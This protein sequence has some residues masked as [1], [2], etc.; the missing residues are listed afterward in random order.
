MEEEYLLVDL[1]NGHVIAR[2]KPTVMQRCREVIGPTLHEELLR[3]QI[4]VSSPVFAEL[5]AASEFFQTIRQC[6]IKVL[7][8][9]GIGLY[10]AGSHPTARWSNQQINEGSHY[11]RLAFH[12]QYVAQRSLMV[13]L[14]I[15]VGTHDIDR[16]Q[17]INALQPWLP[18]FV[19]L[20]TSSPFWCGKHTGYMS[21]RRIA[22]S[23]WLNAGLPPPLDNWIAYQRYLA[24]LQ[25]WS[26]DRDYLWW[27]IRPSRHFPTIEMRM[28]DACPRLEDAL[29][30]AGLFRHLVEQ[31]ARAALPAN[32]NTP[33]SR[34]ATQENLWRAARFGLQGAFIVPG[35]QGTLDAH[36]WLALLQTLYPADNADSERA[37]AHARRILEQ[38]TSAHHQIDAYNHG[39][40]RELNEAQALRTVVEQVM[41]QTRV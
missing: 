29:C 31:C 32:P 28:C 23:E 40:A 5:A 27:A 8:A 20:S 9:E 38:G 6:L 30:I 39:K 3:S 18:L 1:A 7:S 22:Y 11:Q 13:G 21:Y 2:P 10:C 12:Y 24:F 34:W 41:A 33:E 26:V 19:A 37:F 16:M 36:G 14:H 25:R 15:H 35:E 17:L 4:E